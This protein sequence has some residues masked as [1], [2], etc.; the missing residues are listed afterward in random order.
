MN[1]K[2]RKLKFVRPADRLRV[3]E[4]KT[5]TKTNV[6]MRSSINKNF[7]P[8]R[9]IRVMILKIEC[10]GHRNQCYSEETQDCEQNS[11]SNESR[12]NGVRR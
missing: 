1:E 8:E 11:K 9:V 12:G 6:V 10:I 2:K 5:K 7:D 3:Y 4:S